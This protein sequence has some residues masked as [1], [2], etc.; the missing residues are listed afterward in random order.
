MPPFTGGFILVF[1]TVMRELAVIVLL[2]SPGTR[3]L[4][5]MTFRYQEQ[6]YYQFSSAISMM[7]IVIVLVGNFSA[8]K[9][10]R[11]KED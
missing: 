11:V 7:I 4:T 9:I 2:V 6:G 8:K 3:T 5:T 10:A 1:I